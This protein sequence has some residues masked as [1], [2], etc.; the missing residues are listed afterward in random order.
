M[1][2]FVEQSS[3]TEFLSTTIGDLLAGIKQHGKN[4]CMSTWPP[5]NGEPPIVVITATG[6]A[7]DTL[8]R[9]GHKF[10]S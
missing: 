3:K 6:D 10:V 7:A 4:C 2:K 9:V 5:E 8:H 1:P